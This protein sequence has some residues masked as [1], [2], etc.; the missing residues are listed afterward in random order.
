MLKKHLAAGLAPLL[1]C[2]GMIVSSPNN[3]CAETIVNLERDNVIYNRQVE[4]NNAEKSNFQYEPQE[5]VRIGYIITGND[6]ILLDDDT[7]GY[8]RRVLHTK[9]PGNRYPALR[10]K[11]DFDGDNIYRRGRRNTGDT[12]ILTEAHDVLALEFEK[13][14][15]IHKKTITKRIVTD[16]ESKTVSTQ[17]EETGSLDYNE[18]DYSPHLSTLPKDD[19]VEFVRELEDEGLNGYDYLLMFNFKALRSKVKDK[20]FG[21]TRESDFRLSVRAIDVKSG[22]YIDRGEYLKRGYS[23]SAQF[24]IP[25][26]GISLG[27]GPSWRRA[28]RRAIIDAMIESFDHM[29][30]GKYSICDNPYCPRRQD[31][32]RMEKV[33]GKNHRHCVKHCNDKTYCADHMVS[34]QLDA[35][36]PESYVNNEK[37][38]IYTRE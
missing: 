13:L 20:M 35:D 9:F 16:K 32:I 17:V 33:F 36:L 19:Y 21:A 15:D 4:E 25:L 38:P 30:I 12:F 11:N 3:V 1:L 26:L 31:E 34:Y 23:G 6:G 28:M 37:D 2:T 18:Y 8:I 5:G 29:P 22:K 27:S 14:E 24:K 10:L 7:M